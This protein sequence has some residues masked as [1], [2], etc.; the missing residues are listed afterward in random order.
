MSLGRSSINTS[1][2]RCTQVAFSRDAP[3]LDLCQ[4]QPSSGLKCIQPLNARIIGAEGESN[5]LQS[6]A[7]KPFCFGA[8]YHRY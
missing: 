3:A 5:A 7:L 8:I 1:A 4:A 6:L 2:F